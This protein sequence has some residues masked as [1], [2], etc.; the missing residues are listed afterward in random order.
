LIEHLL[1]A[2]FGLAILVLAG[3]ALVRGAV[4]VSLRLGVPALI[5]ALTIVAIGTSAPELLISIQA[6]LDD[7]PGIALGNVVGSN[8]ANILLVL[9]VPA[10][11]TGIN[12]AHCDT[13]ASYLQMLFGTAIFVGAASFGVINWGLGLV[14]LGVFFLFMGQAIRSA[15]GHRKETKLRKSEEPEV[16]GLDPAMSWRKISL[17]VVLGL[18]GLPMGAKI[19]VDG[20]TDIARALHISETIIGLSLVAVGTSLPELATTVSAALRGKADVA[21]GNVIGSNL[22]NLLAI[23]GTASLFGSIPVPREVLVHDV[24][25]MVA[26]SLLIAPFVLLKFN[27]G[28]AWGAAFL[29]AYVIYIVTLF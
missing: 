22:A 24:L 6:V 29:T 12:S 23:M 15:N 1:Y 28:R 18:I 9:G 14:L 17:L 19:F 7:A 13:R 10:L 27:I 3:D 4:N 11:L 26:A 2:V 16:E 20:A 5:V 21:L 8:I 25:F